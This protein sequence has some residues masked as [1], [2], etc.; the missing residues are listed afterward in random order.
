M[1]DFV[2]NGNWVLV[3]LLRRKKVTPK[4]LYIV[5]KRGRNRPMEQICVPIGCC[6]KLEE[7]FEKNK[8]LAVYLDK[9]N[10]R[11][12]LK[13]PEN[14]EETLNKRRVRINKRE[15][16]YYI[17]IIPVASTLGLKNKQ[18]LEYEIFL[19]NSAVVFFPI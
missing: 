14:R 18:R 9:I 7:F 15:N 5:F 19:D 17:T 3:P 10:K 6:A 4:L 8:E 2:E 16:C 1:N 13:V 11:I 12:L